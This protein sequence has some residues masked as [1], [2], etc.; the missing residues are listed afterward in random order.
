M[1]VASGQWK[2]VAID[3]VSNDTSSI[4]ISPRKLEISSTLT[5]IKGGLTVANTPNN[6]S[7]D[8]VLVKNN[9]TGQIEVTH[10]SNVGGG[11]TAIVFSTETTTTD[12][13]EVDKIMLVNCSS[14][15]INIRPVLSPVAGN[16]IAISDSR[17]NAGTH[18]ITI[19]F[20]SESQK[21]HGTVQNYVMNVNADFVEFVYVNATIGWIRKT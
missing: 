2:A 3:S 1:Y 14:G 16:V 4:L 21:L 20:S 5:D 11:S 17:A 15:P 7:P 12:T 19:T 18:N 10:K 8:S 13:A 9:V 6:A